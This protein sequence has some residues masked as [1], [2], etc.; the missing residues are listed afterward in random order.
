VIGVAIKGVYGPPDCS[1]LSTRYPTTLAVVLGA[2]LRVAEWEGVATPVPETGIEIGEFGALLAIVIVPEKV[3]ADAGV[4]TTPSATACPGATIEPASAEDALKLAGE[5]LTALIVAGAFPELVSVMTAVLLEPTTIFPKLKL[6]ESAV[7]C[8]V[9]V[10]CTTESMAGALIKLPAGLL[11]TT[12][13][14]EPS[15]VR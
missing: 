13:K 6:E 15:S 10:G 7:S 9:P 14:I 1:D 12:V 3:A 2:Q 4:N 8:G 5:M 11:T